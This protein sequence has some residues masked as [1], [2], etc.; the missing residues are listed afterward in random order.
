MWQRCSVDIQRALQLSLPAVYRKIVI[1][2]Y[3]LSSLLKH[4]LYYSRDIITAAAKWKK[5]QVVC[6]QSWCSSL[7]FVPFHLNLGRLDWNV[8]W[9]MKASRRLGY[10][11]ELNNLSFAIVTSF[12]ICTRCQE[13]S[14]K[15][16]TVRM[17]N[18]SKSSPKRSD[19]KLWGFVFH[20]PHHGESLCTMEGWRECLYL[21]KGKHRIP[22]AGDNST[23]KICHLN[24]NVKS[25]SNSTLLSNICYSI[26]FKKT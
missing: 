13:A 16:N 1:P 15:G 11:H 22:S 9:W 2:V 5:W 8:R 25:I 7:Y 26:R 19:S 6:T 21:C 10:R 17:E 20:F 12:L 3:C 14:R 23:M 24:I 18:I 4:F